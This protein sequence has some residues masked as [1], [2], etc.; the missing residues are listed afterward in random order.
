MLLG[1]QTAQNLRQFARV[2][3]ARSTRAMA[4]LG[5]TA[6]LLLHDGSPPPGSWILI[7]APPN[8]PRPERL[9]RRDSGSANPPDGKPPSGRGPDRQRR[10]L[11]GPTA[12]STA[13]VS[14][15]L[16]PPS[17]ARGQCDSNS[18][19]SLTIT[20]VALGGAETSIRVTEG[21]ITEIGGDIEI[22]DSDEVID[23]SG[24]AA[25]PGLV[26][27]HT[28]AAMTL[29]RGY[30]D[31]LPL[32]EWLQTRI[33]PA[34]AKLTED[35][36]YW[37][38]RL[39]CLE[40]IRSG[41]T[42]FFD[43]YW[44]GAATARATED[45]GVRAVVSA[46]LIDGGD[47]AGSAE[48]RDNANASL[49]ELHGF[50]PLITPCLGPHAIYTVSDESLEWLAMTAAEREVPIHIHL[51]ETEGEVADCADA[52]GVTPAIHLDHLGLLGSHTLLA[53]GNWLTAEE[54]DLVAERGATVV[55]NPVS[56]MKLANGCIFPY[57]AA[58]EAGVAMGL[59]TDGAS[60]NNNLDLLEEAKVFSL[61][62][63][64]AN[65]DPAIVPAHETLDLAAGR[66]SPLMGGHAVEVG[67]PADLVLVDMGAPELWPGDLEGN[68]VYAAG[69]AVVDTT[70]IGG[71][72]LM[73]GR[74][75]ADEDE[76]RSEAIPRAERLTST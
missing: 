40:M 36:V 61:A 72:I 48:L 34:E 54:L 10:N 59:G 66:L 45:A 15:D 64:H 22:P 35:D 9:T 8:L 24:L 46:V 6:M 16:Q 53:H 70:I 62:Q 39:A 7:L 11:T 52:H 71:E 56:N 38:T 41:T 47:A 75:V 25:L 60:S 69:G 21:T 42:K 19:M 30:G 31:D 43:M 12:E 68:L 32:M 29:F 50:G 1:C 18:W 17:I 67:A 20:D 5:Q 73:R 44:H 4:E 65:D 74:V 3:L 26:N 14:G 63:R 37:G 51:S 13:M 55:T 2:E 27:G 76:I 28:H 49:D 23:G 33:W 57:P 58:R